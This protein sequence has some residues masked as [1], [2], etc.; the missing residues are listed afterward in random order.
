MKKSS[1]KHSARQV[2][3]KAKRVVKKAARRAAKLT[4]AK[5]ASSLKQLKAAVSALK[6]K[7][8]SSQGAAT[9]VKQALGVATKLNRLVK[10]I[11]QAGLLE[12]K[13]EK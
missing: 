2:K 1:A 11:K 13:T 9:R 7:G 3:T 8:K 6:P 5:A 10:S 4:P 12:S